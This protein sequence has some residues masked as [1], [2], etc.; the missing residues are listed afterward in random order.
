MDDH[1]KAKDGSIH[2]NNWQLEIFTNSLPRTTQQPKGFISSIST[3]NCMNYYFIN[4]YGYREHHKQTRKGYRRSNTK[5][6]EQAYET[7]AANNVQD[8]IHATNSVKY[9]TRKAPIVVSIY[10]KCV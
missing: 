10:I 3:S 4:R 1:T 8:C 6:G 2:P 5:H 7:N 9:T